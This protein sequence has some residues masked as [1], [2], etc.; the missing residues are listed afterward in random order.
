MCVDRRVLVDKETPF[1]FPEEM[2]RNMRLRP[3]RN[4]TKRNGNA[5]PG[6]W[7]KTKRNETKWDHKLLA[8]A[9]GHP[10]EKSIILLALL[11]YKAPSSA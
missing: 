4:E 1:R 3:K 10:L 5:A 8:D 7:R 2:K 6:A 11:I 9:L